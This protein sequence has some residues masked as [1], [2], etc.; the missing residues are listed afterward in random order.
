MDYRGSIYE[1]SVYDDEGEMRECIDRTSFKPMLNEYIISKRTLP[2]QQFDSIQLYDWEYMF[3][4]WKY[5][6][7][8]FCCVDVDD[9]IYDNLGWILTI[10]SWLLQ[11]FYVDMLFETN[12]NDSTAVIKPSSSDPN[13]AEQAHQIE[14][15]P[16]PL[17]RRR[18][19][20]RSSNS[21]SYIQAK[22]HGT[23][24]DTKATVSWLEKRFTFYCSCSFL[25]RQ[26]ISSLISHLFPLSY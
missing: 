13:E 7:S 5:T 3:A 26:S 6:S 9:S 22:S 14:T 8:K 11:N 17:P 4:Y 2:D 20:R 23:T 12:E 10:G 21:H 1:L 16:V 19:L 18:S 25:Y 15:R 24:L